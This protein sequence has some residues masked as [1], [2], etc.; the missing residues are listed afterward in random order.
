M[1]VK[2]FC[3]SLKIPGGTAA[4]DGYVMAINLICEF[5][6]MYNLK[7]G[8]GVVLTPVL[9]ILFRLKKSMLVILHSCFPKINICKRASMSY[10]QE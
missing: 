5:N 9:E 3:Y 7:P 6:A 10:A 4:W 8:P 1:L 2:N